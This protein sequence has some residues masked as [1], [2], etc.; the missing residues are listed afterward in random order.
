MNQK[1]IVA[2]DGPA[3][4]GKS[5]VTHL[6]ARKLGYV[7]IDTGALYRAV[8]LK[9]KELG[10]SY[11]DAPALGRC[12]LSCRLE[13]QWLND[14]RN[15]VFLD[16]KNVSSL[17][18]TPEISMAASKI[19]AY[20]EVRDALLGLQRQLGEKGGVVLEGRDIG[21]VVFP[22]AHA[23]FF[24]TAS[25]DSRARRR[26]VELEEKGV[27]LDFEEVKKQVVDRDRGD[28]ERKVAPLKKAADAL[29]VDTTNMTVGQ[30][31]DTLAMIVEERSKRG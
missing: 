9:A 5:T 16:G 15:H 1:L 20:P 29:E 11:D 6:L 12:A 3:G 14:D 22:N 7:H 25:V 10:I 2:I 26:A 27:Y 18:R 17:I 19:S 31:V 28:T 13:F 23:K 4:S 24:L 21:T 30:V 8:A